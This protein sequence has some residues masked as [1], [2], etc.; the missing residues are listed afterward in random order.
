[1][2]RE[3][4]LSAAG[5]ISLALAHGN[6]FKLLHNGSHMNGSINK[7]GLIFVSISLDREQEVRQSNVCLLPYNIF[8]R[9]ENTGFL[10]NN[11][12]KHDCNIDERAS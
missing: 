4:C 7:L 9:V 1:M 6:L 3:T 11:K 8:P 12:G 10:S 5:F 2:E